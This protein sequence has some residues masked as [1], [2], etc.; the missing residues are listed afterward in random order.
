MQAKL[1]KT[2][3]QTAKGDT[4]ANSAFVIGFNHDPENTK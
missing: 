4:H 1:T 2:V 3:A